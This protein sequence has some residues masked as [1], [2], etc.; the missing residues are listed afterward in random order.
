MVDDPKR[1]MWS[2]AIDMLARAERL[3][4]QVFQPQHVSGQHATWEPPVDV[5]ETDDEVLVIAALP[6]VGSNHIEAVIDRGTL[7]I[8]GQRV[9]PAVL[10]DALIHRLE[11]PQ[12]RFQR[13]IPLPPGRYDSVQHSMIDGCLF[14]S[15]R[16]A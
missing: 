1:W 12:G 6:G 9:I 15:L 3:H 4:R 2:D 8:S 10:R 5:L 7:F 16:K 11:L 13:R 14:I